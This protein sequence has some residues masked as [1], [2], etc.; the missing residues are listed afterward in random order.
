MANNETECPN[1]A[2]KHGLIREIRLDN[3]QFAGQQDLFLYNVEHEGF[4]AV[5]SAFSKG[6]FI[7]FIVQQRE[8]N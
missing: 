6:P 5:A 8:L 3:E 7:P 1:C 2:R 4:S